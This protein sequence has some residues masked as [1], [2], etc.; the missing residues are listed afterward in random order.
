MKNK[1][2]F[3]SIDVESTEDKLLDSV[4]ENNPN[5]FQ[6]EYIEDIEPPESN[7]HPLFEGLGDVFDGST[8]RNIKK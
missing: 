8:L 3:Y 7:L 1:R 2:I 4:R 5:G 6:Y